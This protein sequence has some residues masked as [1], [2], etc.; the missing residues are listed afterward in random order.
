M[1][2]RIL[3]NRNEKWRCLYLKYPP[4]LSSE[5]FSSSSPSSCKLT[6]SPLSCR[7][8]MNFSVA[9]TK[10]SINLDLES[11][12][13]ESIDILNDDDYNLIYIYNLHPK[14]FILISGD[15]RTSPYIGYSFDNN[16]QLNNKGTLG[17]NLV[18]SGNGGKVEVQ[19]DMTFSGSLEQV[20][21]HEGFELKIS[22]GKSMNYSGDE[23][24]IGSFLD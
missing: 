23:F 22:S 18:I 13:V 6:N 16:F 5:G 2:S 15:D 12:V 24:K 11:F 4:S 19:E 9:V 14:G 20:A 3:G 7:S 10:F 1:A 21:D 17:A 8:L